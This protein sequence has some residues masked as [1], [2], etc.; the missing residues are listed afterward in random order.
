M[1]AQVLAIVS[2]QW[3]S[4]MRFRRD[5][6]A[7]RRLVPL[8]PMLLWYGTWLALALAA[9]SFTS[10]PGHAGTLRNLLPAALMFL[11][12]YWQ[13]TPLLTASLGATLDLRKLLVFPVPNRYLFGIEVLLRLTTSV[14]VL[15]LLTGGCAGLSVNPAFRFPAAPLVYVPFVV[16]NLCVAAGLR[17][18]LERWLARKRVRELL[19]LGL[20]LLAALPQLLLVTGVPAPMARLIVSPPA[21]YWPWT[22]AAR[23]A[24]GD[25]ILINGAILAA[26]TIAAYVF[27]RWQFERSLRFDA[28]A[29][30]SAGRRGAS[31]SGWLDAVCRLVTRWFRDPMAA[32]MEKE[33]R[34]LTRTPRFRLVFLMG[35]T[36]GVLVFLP[37]TSGSLRRGLH[38]VP[39]DSLV[40]VGAYA[41]L[42]LGDVAFWNVF[43]F[44]RAAAQ[45]YFL[46][47]VPIS[48]V[49]AGKNLAAGV[50]VILEMT[51]IT[52]VW[53]LIRMPVSWEKVLEA[54]AVTLTLTL[55]LLG[56]GNMSSV[57]YPRPI[58]PER[59]TGAGSAGRI[60]MLLL[61]IYPAA[62][63]PVVL[64]YGAR[65]AFDSTPAF[66]GVLA[67]AAAVGSTVYWIGLDTAVERAQADRDRLISTLSEGQ[68]PVT[69][70]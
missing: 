55:Y 20:V 52:L 30:E 64:A 31:S 42:L 40:M 48:R 67:F 44:D 21:R 28:A 60:R 50:F 39:E 12:V 37:V 33:L 35:F 4:L 58:S 68:G 2:A 8:I 47:P 11:L 46:L 5:E 19:V 69:P 13:A 32:V 36:F 63:L 38:G 24:V 22:A 15:L 57:Y 70:A 1:P 54:Y 61:L 62:A 18:Q 51:A 34:S 45:A 9:F 49:I 26:W 25:G 56:A 6:G 3:K 59:S 43:G 53:T 29:A 17:N 14:E 23:L 10:D 65:F 66:W 27:G 16:M 41:L 7:A